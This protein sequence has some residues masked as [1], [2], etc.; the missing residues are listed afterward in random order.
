MYCRRQPISILGTTQTLI[1]TMN[2]KSRFHSCFPIYSYIF[3]SFYLRA[4]HDINHHDQGVTSSPSPFERVLG[5]RMD[6]SLSPGMHNSVSQA[7][8]SSLTLFENTPSTSN[9]PDPGCQ[10]QG[11]P[12]TYRQQRSGYYSDSAEELEGE[13]YD[14][15]S[16]LI[17][18][19]EI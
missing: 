4:L 11:P 1:G 3:Y 13:E 5:P 15:D 8:H 17:I 18:F 16:K 14:G 2:C 7:Q 10:S 19:P 6:S 9:Y 12:W